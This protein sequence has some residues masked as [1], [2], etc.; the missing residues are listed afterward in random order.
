MDLELSKWQPEGGWQ[1]EEVKQGHRPQNNPL[2]EG[3]IVRVGVR[4]G[5]HRSDRWL[6]TND[7]IQNISNIDEPNGRFFF[8]SFLHDRYYFYFNL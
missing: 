8:R 1:E 5:R 3:V 6:C 7:L 4:T 2:L